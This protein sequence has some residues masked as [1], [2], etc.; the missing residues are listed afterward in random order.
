MALNNEDLIIYGDGKSTRDF[1]FVNDVIQANLSA[2]LSEKSD[3]EAINI[4]YGKT[5]SIGDLANMIIEITNSQSS[6]VFASSRAGDIVHSAA[7]LTKAN[8]LI[9]YESQ[10]N[11]ERGLSMT[12]DYFKQSVSNAQ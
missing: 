1:V 3:G 10:T 8:M 11:M 9:D 12:I 5:I 7:D 2:A 6:I 4:A